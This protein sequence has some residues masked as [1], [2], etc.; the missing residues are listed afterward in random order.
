MNRANL[1]VEER[2]NIGSGRAERLRKSGYIPA[3]IYGRGVETTA[4]QVKS[5]DFK[6]FLSKHGRNSIFTTKFASEQDVTMLVKDV[7]FDAFSKNVIHADFQRVSLKE[8]LHVEVPVKV[9]GE[10]KLETTNSVIVHQLNNVAVEC[11]PQ[12]VPSY[13]GA[14]ISGMAPGHSL[15]A[16]QLTIPQNVTIITDPNDI[17][18][19]ITDGKLNLQVDNADEEIKPAGE[20]GKTHAAPVK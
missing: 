11:L 14:D 12:D 7:Q 16:S 3:V 4:V 10:D 8:K 6:E 5:T 15:K 2:K 19:S 13:V 1:N 9:L 18:L 17:I 20:E